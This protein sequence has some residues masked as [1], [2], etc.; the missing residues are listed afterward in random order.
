MWWA[1]K[2]G[3]L[4]ATVYATRTTI[5]DLL[6]TTPTV[7][8]QPVSGIILVNMLGYNYFDLWLT[9]TYIGY[10]IAGS[11]WLLVVWI[12]IP[13]RNMALEALKPRIPLPKKYYKLFK[14]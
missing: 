13:L 12:Q 7:I 11:C 6:F 14:L 10:I 1:N 2:T 5:A 3:D 8:I 4:N 9:L